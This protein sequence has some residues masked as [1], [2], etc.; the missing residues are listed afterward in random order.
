[1]KFKLLADVLAEAQAKRDGS[2]ALTL[3]RLSDPL[4]RGALREIERIERPYGYEETDMR[5]GTIMCYACHV[6]GAP[7]DEVPLGSLAALFVHL[8]D[9][10]KFAAVIAA[11]PPPP[12]KAST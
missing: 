5:G 6:P 1:M 11:P 10:D 8:L 9:C 3:L 7:P 2:R 4:V 12:T